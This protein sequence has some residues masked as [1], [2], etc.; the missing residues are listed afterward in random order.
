M[1]SNT[2]FLVFDCSLFLRVK[3]LTEAFDTEYEL[4]FAE[5]KDSTQIAEVLKQHRELIS[6]IEIANIDPYIV[7]QAY[8]NLV[9]SAINRICNLVNGKVDRGIAIAAVGGYGRREMCPY[10]DVDVAFISESENSE[11]V[12][13]ILKSV[14]RMLMDTFD[15]AGLKI[16]YSFR[17]IHEVSNLSIETSTALLDARIIAGDNYLMSVFQNNL[18]N[19]IV[20][21]DFVN[22]HLKNRDLLFTT[23][24]TPYTINPNIKEGIGGLRDLQTIEWISRI[25][26]KT[27]DLSIPNF[28][29]SRGILSDNDITAFHNAK[30]FLFKTR[31]IMHIIEN[32][33]QN[34]LWPNI[35]CQLASSLSF[36][37]HEDFMSSYYEHAS[38]IRRLLV[39]VSEACIEEPLEIEPGIICISGYIKI[40]DMDLLV[41]DNSAA[42]RLFKY[43]QEYSLILHRETRNMI[44][45]IVDTWKPNR[46]SSQA[47]MDIL[48]IPGSHR[49]IQ[50][51]S[52]CGLLQCLI[53]QFSQLMFL[54]SGDS[55]HHYTIGQHT[56]KAMQELEQLFCAGSEIDSEIMSR[57]QNLEVL[58]LAVLMHDTGKIEAH[59]DH[60]KTGAHIASKFARQLGMNSESIKQVEF[61]VRHHLRMN[62]T[63]R[64]RDL[65]LPKTIRDFTSV[66]KD[67]K[68]LDML[69]LLSIADV[70]AIGERKRNPVQ[71]RFLLELYERSLVAIKS[72]E[73]P[74]V[75][76][77]KHK[78]RV[79]RELHLANLPQIEVDEHCNSMPA[80]YLLNT[81]PEEL[82]QHISYLISAKT[83]P[84]VI[85][86]RDEKN[87]E[88]TQITVFAP[89]R[90]GLLRDIAGTLSGLG[91]SIHAAQAYTR[92]SSDHIAIDKILV[93]YEGRRLTQVWKWQVENKLTSVIRDHVSVESIW[94]QHGKQIK[95]GI[96]D[97][98]ILCPGNISDNHTVLEIRADDSPGLLYYLAGMITDREWNIHSARISTWGHLARDV[99]YITDSRGNMIS[100]DSLQI[101][102]SDIGASILY[103]Q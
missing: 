29:R 55:A 92:K 44:R 40:T 52:Q 98:T 94:L 41:R 73:T 78:R 10:S 67:T 87:A 83:E 8:S 95:K 20:P 54:L 26:F 39:N 57:I 72:P 13:N 75:D 9:D 5:A 53:P 4:V 34:T 25:S 71:M 19:A 77:E 70:N 27:M 32:R 89:D 11:S 68:L 82:A 56:I 43:C 99:F 22:N 1:Q 63:A 49:S 48:S 85:D 84:P 88:Y 46:K 42:V 62:E 51:M 76:I 35:A 17:Q 100:E 65:N 24:K 64:L 2:V 79:R 50:E 69:L 7:M 102:A 80:S 12:D 3:E 61:L 96:G 81:N 6:S 21:C 74:V 14:F 36:A 60:A 31:I 47:F 30:H 90:Y 18:R 58:N 97:I 86:I 66:I 38:E 33:D 23:N 93:D 15:K 45:K 28:L 59:K 101:F 103:A 91:L 16:G 37:T